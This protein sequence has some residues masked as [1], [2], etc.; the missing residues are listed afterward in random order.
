MK[1]KVE[2]INYKIAFLFLV[3]TENLLIMLM[4]KCKDRF[5]GKFL[6]MEEFSYKVVGK[7]VVLFL[8]RCFK[9]ICGKSVSFFLS[10]SVNKFKYIE[11]KKNTNCHWLRR[12]MA[13]HQLT[14]NFEHIATKI[15]RKDKKKTLLFVHTWHKNF[16]YLEYFLDFG[17]K[18]I[19]NGVKKTEYHR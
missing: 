16:H 4:K 8:K 7:Y 6:W 12:L 17:R 5:L 2:K 10:I 3:V 9:K 13:C 11:E 14:I 1:A 19:Q 15:T 18:I